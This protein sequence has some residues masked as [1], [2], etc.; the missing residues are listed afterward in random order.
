MRQWLVAALAASGLVA[1]G[2]ALIKSI[3]PGI[4]ALFQPQEPVPISNPL[5]HLPVKARCPPRLRR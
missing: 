5:V 2:V 3:F 1:I 4:K